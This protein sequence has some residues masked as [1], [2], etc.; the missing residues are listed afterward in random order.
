MKS[1]KVVVSA[2][3]GVLGLIACGPSPQLGGLGPGPT[4]G[5]VVNNSDDAYQSCK[6]QEKLGDASTCWKKW[7]AENGNTGDS[8]Q[9][10]YAKMYIAH[11]PQH[12]P[13]ID[14]GPAPTPGTT[15]QNGPHGPVK[16]IP[17]DNDQPAPTK[18]A[19]A[20]GPH[21]PERTA[22]DK[23]CW[24]HMRLTGKYVDDYNELVARC[25]KPTGMLPFSKPVQGELSQ[26]HKGDIYTI[27]LVGG[28]CYRFFAVADQGVKDLDV[29]I[30][31][32]ENKVLWVDKNSQHVAIVDWD[33]A[34][35]VDQDVQFKFIVALDGEGGGG[36]G[37]GIWVRPKG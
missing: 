16:V 26:E 25:G 27:K 35:C 8:P 2:A 31:S 23:E 10:D 20:G 17:L 24:D 15:P 22:G 32:M 13:N 7:L 30:A 19:N 37:F 11:H 3:F 28:G 4:P 14:P 18:P 29:A 6:D 21:F 1:G 36:Y 12:N 33:K 9:K 34:I 5:P